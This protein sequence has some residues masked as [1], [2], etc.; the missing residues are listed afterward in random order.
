MHDLVGGRSGGPFPIAL[1]VRTFPP[2]DRR[3]LHG[4]WL[5]LARLLALPL[6]YAFGFGAIA[7]GSLAFWRA[8]RAGTIP[9]SGEFGR[10]LAV[11]ALSGIVVATFLRSTL[12]NND[13]G[14]RVMLLPLLAGTVWTIAV[15]DRWL[16]D[17]SD[18]AVAGLTSPV[19]RLACGLGWLTVLYAAV[20]MR[21]YPFVPIDNDFRF[22]AQDPKGQRALRVA[23]DW[24]DAHL[25]PGRVMQQ[26]P[27]VPRAFAFGL[28]GRNPTGVADAFGSL[29]GADP[30][31]VDQRLAALRP[32]FTTGLSDAEVA[33]R[34]A[35]N[36]VDDLVVTASDP[37]WAD[38][39][40]FVWRQRPLFAASGV[41]IFAVGTHEASR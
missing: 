21:A 31:A 5:Y 16:A 19:F 41:R 2:L 22:M 36:G 40:S 20:M 38:P 28:Y 24:A 18:P 32:I 30:T 29:Y 11:A 33:R 15:L 37:V 26:S 10:V 27:A 4:A 23:F 8:R 14:W 13:L 35:G 34:A 9:A 39:T 12:Y 17:R 6:N 7:L 3:L 1:T 25:P